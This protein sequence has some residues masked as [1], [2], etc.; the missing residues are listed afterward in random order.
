MKS[1][2]V[3]TGTR[4]SGVAAGAARRGCGVCC[5]W[6]VLAMTACCGSSTQA[7]VNTFSGAN[8]ISLTTD[9]N[10]TMVAT[11]GNPTEPTAGTYNIAPT[12]STKATDYQDQLFT[13]VSG[14]YTSSGAS[15]RARSMNVTNGSQL[16]IQAS[17]NSNNPQ[18][19]LGGVG[20]FSGVTPTV[21]VS[22]TGSF[23]N[24][25]SGGTNDAVYLTNNSSLTLSSVNFTAGTG[26]ATATL[27]TGTIAVVNF[28]VAAGSTF[29]SDVVIDGMGSNAASGI[30]VK[31]GG[32]VVLGG[33]NTFTGLTTVQSGTLRYATSDALSTG[34]VTVA[35]G[36]L[37]L[38]TYND[39]VGAVTLA[40]GTITATTGTLTGASYTMSQGRVGAVLAGNSAGLTLTSTSGTVTLAGLNT[41]GGVT[42][43]NGGVLSTDSIMT[44]GAASGIGN[45]GNSATNLVIDGGSLQYTGTATTTS[46]KFVVGVSGATIEN[47]GAG[48]LGFVSST[49]LGTSGNGSRTLALT[50]TNTSNDNVFEPGIIDGTG[51]AT[52]VVKNGSGNWVLTGTNGSSTYSGNT[53]I[54]AGILGVKP[55]PNGTVAVLGSGTLVFNG[56]G[57]SA[58]SSSDATVTNKVRVTSDFSLGGMGVASLT[59][60]GSIDLTGATRAVTLVNNNPNTISGVISNGGLT[61]AST[62][63]ART[64][65][66]SGLNTYSGNTTVD[67]GIL[68]A[69]GVNGFGTGS[70][71]VNAQGAID[72]NSLAVA[73]TITNNGG[74]ILNAG[75]YSG[76]QTLLGVASFSSLGGTLNVG[77][78]GK[79]TLN[80]AIAGTIATLTGGTTELASGGSLT[81][82]SVANAG[83]FIFSGTASGTTTLST[84]FS[85]AG[86]FLKESA[87]ILAL[88]GSSF[89]GAGTQITAGGL[90][91]TGSIGG[92]L[93]DVSSAASIGGT[94]R[95]GGDLNLQAGAIFSF[96]PGNT[97]AVTGSAT[98]G[99]FGVANIDGLTSST[100]D[101][102]YTLMSGLINFANVSNV[103]AGNAYSLGGNKSAYLQQGSMDLVVVPE[104]S[105]FIVG[106]AGLWAAVAAIRRRTTN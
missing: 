32:L 16:V 65:T 102:T 94:G 97:L 71:T 14:T 106:I 33:L 45:S 3:T 89:F 5:M 77:N 6:L 62:N 21:T 41:Y 28:N 35:G 56:G 92:G 80:G 19:W 67:G 100:P 87:S 96:V 88:S 48:S 9:S 51:G 47:V 49:V 98:F 43:I 83:T 36:V 10:W 64:L 74:T 101:G 61:L 75:S 22:N 25:V 40:S 69:G 54:N 81:Q 39:I 57:L 68:K 44:G 31:G 73:N 103:G 11:L 23:M 7:A 8:G 12:S 70:V 76:T 85:G 72:L 91:V 86:S 50:G 1:I 84:A 2:I 37:D 55:D 38:S 58:N 78:T 4:L 90:L 59:L 17:G 26:T 27:R 95:I 93:V 42:T 99:G 46:R 66:L 52:S 104:P 18:L 79:A 34:G 30:T 15:N 24:E 60:S 29:R 13:A 63:S 53:T 105:V 82:S 20:T